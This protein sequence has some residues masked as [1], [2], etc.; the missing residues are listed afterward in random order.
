MKEVAILLLVALMLNGC[1]STTTA[2]NQAGGTW[3]AQ[4][5]GGEAAESG[6]SFSTQFTLNGA[7]ALDVS[8]FQ[9]LNSNAG[10]CFPF[11]G[12]TPTGSM[13]FTI[14]SND[15]VTGTLLFVVQSGGNTLTLNGTVTGTASSATTLSGLS[16]TGTWTLVGSGTPTG[17]N[18]TS[19]SFT[20]TQ[21]ST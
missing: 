18:D 15:S 14:T 8:Y 12:E 17:C 9:F 3:E 19:G 21:S 4:L 5:L 6:F 20:M 13:P 16:I 2:Q 7:N 1:S 11:S 10:Q